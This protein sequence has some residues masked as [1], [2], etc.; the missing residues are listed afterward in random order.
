VKW[1]VNNIAALQI[2][3]MATQKHNNNRG[4]KAQQTINV[5]VPSRAL[6]FVEKNNPLLSIPS[7]R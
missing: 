5:I 7:N 2:I 1:N 3:E 4:G 6:G